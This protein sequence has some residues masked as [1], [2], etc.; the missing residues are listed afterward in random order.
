V[1]LADQE[2]GL[3]KLLW[4]HLR[5]L[6]T[7]TTIRRVLRDASSGEGGSKKDLEKRLGELAPRLKDEQ[8]TDDLRKSLQGQLESLQQRLAKQREA[9]DKLAFVEAELTRLEEQV[10]LIREQAM[11]ST[12][13]TAVSERIDQV[14]ETLGN[15]TQW[16]QEQ[17]Q[18]YGQVEDL[19]SDAQPVLVP[20]ER[21]SQ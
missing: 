4:I 5:L 10:E 1:N 8:L 21:V 20:R 17:Q 2:V 3:G 16:I 11:L 19:L 15:T 7:R 12:D 18:I 14:A 6:L 13:A 9:R